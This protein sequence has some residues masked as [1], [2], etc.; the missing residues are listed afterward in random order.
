ML[1]G[2]STPSRD[3]VVQSP[4]ISKQK[5]QIILPLPRCEYQVQGVSSSLTLWATM[6]QDV[7]ILVMQRSQGSLGDAPSISV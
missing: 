3:T 4:H 7:L 1:I 6:G 5:T 2:P